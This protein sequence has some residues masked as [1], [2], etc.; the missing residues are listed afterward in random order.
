M[1]TNNNDTNNY[2]V[3]EVDVDR[4]ELEAQHHVVGCRRLTGDRRHEKGSSYAGP[5]RRM[6][7]D[8]RRQLVD[9]RVNRKE[10]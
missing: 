8:R 3:S 2:E 10:Q 9:R 1:K 5:P 7:P 6:T 4:V